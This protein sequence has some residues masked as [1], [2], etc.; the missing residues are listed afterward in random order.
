MTERGSAARELLARLAVHNKFPLETGTPKLVCILCVELLPVTG[1]TVSLMAHTGHRH[2]AGASDRT[3]YQLEQWQFTLNEGPSVEAF[4]TG[5]P[6]WTED[7]SL[8]DTRWP[9]LS[10][11]MLP[12]VRAIHAFP[13]QHGGITIGVLV[14][15]R[16]NPGALTDEEHDECLLVAD[17]VSTALL[18]YLD[19]HDTATG[20]A[21]GEDDNGISEAIGMAMVQLGAS[22]E[23]ALARM[24]AAA[25]VADT[26]LDDIATHITNR[27]LRFDRE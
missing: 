22:A 26:T 12:D 14:L 13:L 3:A 15:Y 9:L 11:E 10:S 19:R 6:V 27:S 8:P 17:A 4:T 2:A 20:V 23:T 24:R 21:S 1:A 5:L 18:T 25:F 7:L 16:D